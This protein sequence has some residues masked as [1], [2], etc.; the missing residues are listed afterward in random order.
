[1]RFVRG[2]GGF[3][4]RRGDEGSEGRGVGR[5]GNGMK[6]TFYQRGE[7]KGLVSL[8]LFVFW[9]TSLSSF[10][11]LLLTLYFLSHSSSTPSL[12][13]SL[14]SIS[15]LPPSSPS[16]LFFQSSIL[17]SS[18][19]PIPYLLISIHHSFILY[20]LNPHHN[21]NQNHTHIQGISQSR[22]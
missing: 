4:G 17:T 19:L 5:E 10:I 12:P 13:N 18:S 16:F 15:I 6:R 22:L 9:N 3:C 20:I 8:A 1:M 14:S 7:S 21:H 11:L 2:G